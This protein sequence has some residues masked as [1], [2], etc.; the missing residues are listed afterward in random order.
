MIHGI[1]GVAIGGWLLSALLLPAGASAAV[2]V[3]VQAEPIV[4]EGSW[5]GETIVPG[6][7]N[8]PLEAVAVTATLTCEAGRCTIAG[9]DPVTRDEVL[10]LV[11]GTGSFTYPASGSACDSA[12]TRAEQIDLVATATSLTGTILVSPQGPDQCG[13]TTVTRTG[14]LLNY[15]LALVSGDPCALDD[16]CVTATPTP[17]AVAV[18]PD[19]AGSGERADLA[20]PSILSTLPTAA[21]V[22]RNLLWA[23][24]GAVILVVLV[25]LPTALFDS[26]IDTA[27]TRLG[28]WWRRRR[29]LSEPEK[30]A[31]EPLRVRGFA[32]AA[33]GVALAAVI[34]SFVDP[35]FG[36]QPVS[37]RVLLSM[38]VGFAITFVLGW[39]AVIRL[40]RRTHPEAK[41]RFE[42]VPLTLI[43]VV[44]AVVLSRIS[45]FEPAIVFGL[46]AG[47]VFAGIE[48]AQDKAR[49]ALATLGYSFGIALLAWIGYSL[50][51][52]VSAPSAPV[53][54]IQETLSGLV[55][56]GIAAIP[57]VLLPVRGLPGAAVWRWK[58]RVWGV[59]YGVGLFAFLLVLLPMPSSWDRV[60]LGI[61]AWG[62]LFAAY[63]L[64]ALVLWLVVNRKA[65]VTAEP[66]PA[67]PRR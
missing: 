43:V 50:L 7:T 60:G 20:T 13:D 62:G 52:Q 56:A 28:A 47:V 55:I 30:G 3:A 64:A 40:T 33:G 26:A 34:S 14:S 54:F 1:A 58:R 16:S 42:F 12:N 5:T 2:P 45:G 18:A 32:A 39:F 23:A 9:I 46:V 44:L 67:H 15:D 25:A 27:T 66:E 38:L 41:P 51:A 65:R 37:I 4:Y 24:I 49:Q 11:D 53:V 8:Q 59:V 36:I 48:S 31:T 57:L 63:A 22:P 61:W 19:D 35:S 10:E 21:S 29:G 17:T 6:G